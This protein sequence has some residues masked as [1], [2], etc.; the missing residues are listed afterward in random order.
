MLLLL[1]PAI[2]S[3]SSQCNCTNKTSAAV[4]NT[5]YQLTSQA[6]THKEAAEYCVET[7]KD[8][9]LAAITSEQIADTIKGLMENNSGII[10]VYNLLTTN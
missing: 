1:Y 6:M 10:L 8:G 5:C 3:V 2:P 4:A 7:F 9:S